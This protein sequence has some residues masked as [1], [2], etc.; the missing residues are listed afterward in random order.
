MIEQV[1][2]GRRQI[3]SQQFR[4]ERR[5]IGETPK[6]STTTPWAAGSGTVRSTACSMIASVPSDP[7]T[8]RPS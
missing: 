7:A 1:A 4:H 5:G 3:G 6:G 2:R 8:S